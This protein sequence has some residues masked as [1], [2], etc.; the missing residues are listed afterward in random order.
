MLKEVKW[1]NSSVKQLAGNEDPIQVI[2]EKTRSM[3]LDA[4]DNG[5]NGPPFD[6]LSLAKHLGFSIV[7]AEDILDA[8]LIPQEGNDQI[9]YNPNRA[10]TRI[11]FSIA[12]EIA[13]TLFPDYKKG[14]HHRS[15]PS[16]GSDEWQ[17]ELLCNVAAGEILM[18]FGP[19]SD[20]QNTPITMNKLVEIQKKYDVS[21]ESVLLRMIK[22]TNQPI[23]IFAASRRR[24][25]KESDFRVDYSINSSTSNLDLKYGAKISSES[26]LAECTGIGF[27]AKR[28]EKLFNEFP[29]WDIECVGIPAYPNSIYPRVLGIIKTKTK[30]TLEPLTIK[31]LRGDATEPRGKGFKIIAHIVNDESKRWGRGF[32]FSISKKWP[33]VRNEFVKWAYEKK[34]KLGTCH[35]TPVSDDLLIF[36]MI[37]QHGYGNSPVP[38]IRY[39]HLRNCLEQLFF[40]AQN[41]SA[42][43][44]MPRIGTGFAGGDWNV[45]SELIDQILVKRGIPVII[46]DLPG[47][48]APKP[49]QSIL[50]FVE[51]ISM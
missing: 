49:K 40:I 21:M 46:Y 29:E 4:I 10:R 22:I 9:E 2:I 39:K 8:R 19:E 47:N 1:T 13:H 28:R 15:K 41:N 35:Q 45:I 32:G 34:I 37:A 7:P 23:T 50:D 51:N 14:I 5:W 43:V 26:V 30:S 17:L 18:P 16:I 48:E 24:E 27:T 3:V 11:K 31:Y 38:R 36:S 20:L 33:I 6:P 44:H 12:H 42:T 25:D